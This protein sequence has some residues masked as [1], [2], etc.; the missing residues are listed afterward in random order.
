MLSSCCS[1]FLW[2]N[3]ICCEKFEYWRYHALVFKYLCFS[4]LLVSSLLFTD[5]CISHWQHCMS[6][7]ISWSILC[8]TLCLALYVFFFFIKFVRFIM[9]NFRA[10]FMRKDIIALW[11]NSI[12]MLCLVCWI[13]MYVCI[14]VIAKFVES[15][16]Y[17]ML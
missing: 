12:L 6:A 1:M 11:T 15:G 7:T 16:Q 3:F 2:V 17:F 9:F 14:Q 10:Y 5:S 8:P 4:C 13:K